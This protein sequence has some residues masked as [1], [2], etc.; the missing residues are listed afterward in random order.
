[1]VESPTTFIK[2]PPIAQPMRGCSMESRS[3]KGGDRGFR[4]R[5]DGGDITEKSLSPSSLAIKPSLSML[6]CQR[7]IK[8]RGGGQVGNMTFPFSS[9][10]S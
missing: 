3:I 4:I 7:S 6:D 10:F 5:R 2:L 9:F 1:M 8:R